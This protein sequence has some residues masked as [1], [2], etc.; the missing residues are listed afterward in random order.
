[1]LN[2][3]ELK[4]AFN[5]VMDTSGGELVNLFSPK[6]TKANLQAEDL[7]FIRRMANMSSRTIVAET[8]ELMSRRLE[9]T[10]R[11]EATLINA[12]RSVLPSIEVIDAVI[13]VD[14]NR[15]KKSISS[16]EISCGSLN[17]LHSL[18]E[19]KQTLNV[20]GERFQGLQ[21]FLDAAN[22]MEECIARSHFAEAW[23]LY[24]FTQRHLRRGS[25]NELGAFA[26]LEAELGSAK[27]R[28]VSAIEQTLS[29]QPLKVQETNNLLL[30]YRM[31]F[32]K[33]DLK[34]KY[35]EWRSSFYKYRKL[36]ITKSNT[37][38]R[39]IK[40]MLELARVHLSEIVHQFRSIF[41]QPCPVLSR[42]MVSEMDELLSL[43]EA[44]LRLVPSESLFQSL[45]EVYT[46][47]S[48]MKLFDINSRLNKISH[49]MVSNMVTKST[50]AA[51][52]TFNGELSNYNWKPFM[53]LIPEGEADDSK[54]IHLT[55]NRP[56]AIL[57]NDVANILNDLRTFPLISVKR[58][59]IHEIDT[60][61][62]SCLDILLAYP[63]A[64]A[65]ELTAAIKNICVVLVPTVERY[66]D[67]VF[68]GT[69]KLSYT[70]EHPRFPQDIERSIQS[71]PF[72]IDSVEVSPR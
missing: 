56:L 9:L 48:Y 62:R 15:I 18:R 68:G 67:A 43:I 46:V 61:I 26:Q 25:L 22:L 66:L 19:E 50:S 11:L 1:M 36:E 7:V 27:N 60:L 64:P 29:T 6:H 37:P 10:R 2:G 28:L 17:A 41:N 13:R 44:Q 49:D 32:P 35:M 30:I 55:R 42:F 54:L 8:T 47:A 23:S 59:T 34:E 14:V 45:S 57:Y 72:P 24:E 52:K 21:E 31:I 20:L 3:S 5:A 16:F 40:D 71:Q 4:L 69:I 39:V 53:S 58:I 70:R 51:L 65:V 12:D 63:S 38:T 33:V